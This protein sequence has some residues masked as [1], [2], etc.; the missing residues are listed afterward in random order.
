VAAVNS[1]GI[2]WAEETAVAAV[3]SSGS[4]CQK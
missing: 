4:I 1:S 3:D 2:N